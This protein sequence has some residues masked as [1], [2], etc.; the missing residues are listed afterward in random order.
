MIHIW[1]PNP[2]APLRVWQ[3]TTQTWQ[4]A[5]NWQEVATLISLQQPNRGKQLQACLYFPS[6]NLLN[7]QPTLTAPQLKGL[8]ESGRQY[9]FEDI[10]ISSVEDLQIKSQISDE[11]TTLYA[12]HASDRD[13]WM[14][15]AQ[16]AGVEIIALLP[17]YLLLPTGGS[18]HQAYF[19]QDSATQLLRYGMHGMAVS[20]LPLQLT[21]LPQLTEVVLLGD[22]DRLNPTLLEQLAMLPTVIVEQS[23]QQPL[24]VTDPAR[25]LLNFATMKRDTKVAPYLK[26]IAAVFVAALLTGL[27]VDGLRWFYYQKAE[28]QAKGLLKQQFEQWFPNEKFNTRLS[29][30]RQ[31]SGKL[32]NEQGD[33]SNVMATL[34]SIQPVLRQYQI[35]AQSLNYQNNHLQLQ[36]IAKDNDSLT[37]AVNAMTAQGVAAKLGNVTQNAAL[38]STPNNSTNPLPAPQS[39]AISGATASV[40]ISL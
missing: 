29:M 1:L 15:A 7:I 11:R 17:D 14:N 32:L 18:S 2:Q 6:M 36:L 39:P 27:L 37:K 3:D 10:S 31:L 5:D 26:V 35:N 20:H 13:A 8:G 19:Y 12:L 16:L 33:K 21:K 34:S 25:Q 30:Q 4:T 24:P 9:L 38:L 22:I 40:E 28:Q 23:A